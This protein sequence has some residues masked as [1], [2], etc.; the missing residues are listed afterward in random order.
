M[1][2]H[3]ERREHR[4]R[5]GHDDGEELLTIGALG[6][7][8]GL[9]VRTIRFWS[10]I[11]VTPP[12]GR[13]TSGYRLYDSESVARLE[14]VRTL[15]DLGF[16][17]ETVRR[18]LASR[19]TVREVA[20]TH[21]RALDAE[22]RTLRIRRAVLRWIARHGSTTE[23]MRLMHEL[24]RMSADQRQRIIDDFVQEVFEGVPSTSPGAGIADA[25]RALPAELPADPTSEQL[26]AWVELGSLVRDEAFRRRVREMA[27]AGARPAEAPTGPDPSRVQEL[28]G[29]A[30]REGTDPASAEAR[31]VLDQLVDP[32][33]ST[34]ER[35]RL[36]DQLATFTDAKV[37]RY[38]QLLGVL[39][40]WPAR[41]SA[42]PA[43]DWLIA[44][45]RAHPTD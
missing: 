2:D 1:S 20:A 10:D 34:G 27:V 44:A 13:S 42:V 15:R 24:A 6:R 33:L 19:A 43:F 17:L 22:I 5:D 40:D 29:G 4:E 14:L 3:D 30:A 21:L 28:A 31:T 38:W 23:E 45:L 12:V 41:P 16:D 25:M 7:R 36:A 11:G 37:E 39:N 32:G 18:V 9:P 35:H 26:E 8:T